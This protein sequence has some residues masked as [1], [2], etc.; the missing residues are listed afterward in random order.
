MRP[1]TLPTRLVKVATL[2]KKRVGIVESE[3][4]KVTLHPLFFAFGLYN[5]LYGKLWSFLVYTLS[6]LLHEFGH[7]LVAGTCGYS[8]KKLS[9]MPYGATLTGDFEDLRFKDE[10]KVVLAGPL[11]SF[12]IAV[13]ISA[14]WWF[15][16]DSYPFTQIAFEANL[17]IF[18]VN[19]LPVY[20]LDGG[21]LISSCSKQI[22]GKERGALLLKIGGLFVSVFLTTA[23][24]FN[25]IN[26][27]NFPSVNFSLLF[28]SAF[29]FIGAFGKRKSQYERAFIG[30]KKESVYRGV[31]TVRFAVSLDTTIKRV[32]ALLEPNKYNEL[33]I[34]ENGSI[35]SQREIEEIVS[36]SPIYFTVGECFNLQKGKV[37]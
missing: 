31:E 12:C 35:I 14:L 5:A 4:F 36:F 32:L 6:A 28:F 9:L 26:S 24:I 37:D 1:R 23:F 18:S 15:Y 16:P 3:S 10:L 2:R 27:S 13:G 21:R 7:A 34:V 17:S 20:P 19:L 25:C 8:I 11:T 30:L 33:F 29:I 22:F